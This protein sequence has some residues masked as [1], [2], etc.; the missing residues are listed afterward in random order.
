MIAL[1]PA[2]APAVSPGERLG[3]SIRDRREALGLSQQALAEKAGL[4]FGQ[5]V[6]QIE[7][8]DREVKAWELVALA[9]ALHTTIDRLLEVEEAPREPR[10]LWRRAVRTRDEM[11]DARVREA[12]LLDRARRYAQLEAWCNEPVTAPLPDLSFD[13]ALAGRVGFFQAERLAEQVRLLLELGSVPGATLARTLEDTHGVKLFFERLT[14]THDGDASAACVRGDFGAA[15]LLDAS[16]AP[17]RQTFSLAHEVF[18]L[19]TWTAVERAWANSGATGDK[20]PKWYAR[21]EQYAD[22]FASALLLPEGSLTARYDRRTLG[23]VPSPYDLAQLAVEFGVSTQALVYRLQGLKRLT[24]AQA[25]QLVSDPQVQEAG[26]QLRGKSP[27]PPHTPFSPRYVQL[28]H[29]AFQRGEVGLSVI[30]R[31]LETTLGALRSLELE[32]SNDTSHAV[33][34]SPAV[35]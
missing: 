19:V 24:A 33:A 21:L 15:I 14:E 1:D 3:S 6:A 9:K 13:L 32:P 16:E 27:A 25:K 30:A 26:R 12:Q 31:Y 7:A 35:A 20:D 18:H 2:P 34:P 29:W 8:G 22:A 5:K 10:V 28:A 4:K 11:Q 23:G 17:W